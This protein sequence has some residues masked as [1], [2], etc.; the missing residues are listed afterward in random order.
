[1]K[2]YAAKWH[3]VWIRAHPHE[4]NAGPWDWGFSLTQN[5]R[6]GGITDWLQIALKKDAGCR[7]KANRQRRGRC[8][9]NS[10]FKFSVPLFDNYHDRRGPSIL[11]ICLLCKSQSSNKDEFLFS[12]AVWPSP[13]PIKA[14]DHHIAKDFRKSWFSSMKHNLS[15][16][17]WF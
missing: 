4:W 1:M 9:K 15:L 16:N 10:I 14:S 6:A 8:S 12:S 2:V 17:K 13:I 11:F 5:F 3:P 7:G